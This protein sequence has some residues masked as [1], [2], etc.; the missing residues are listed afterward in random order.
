MAPET[1][2][3]TALVAPAC[4]QHGLVDDGI[5]YGSNGPGSLAWWRS[6]TGTEMFVFSR[7]KHSKYSM[8]MHFHRVSHCTEYITIYAP[9]LPFAVAESRR[10]PLISSALESS[11]CSATHVGLGRIGRKPLG[12][13]TM[14]GWA[15]AWPSRAS[16]QAPT[17]TNHP[18]LNTTTTTTRIASHITGS[19]GYCHL[20]A[21]NCIHARY[22]TATL[23]SRNHLSSSTLPPPWTP[24]PVPSASAAT[25]PN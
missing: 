23:A 17:I 13:V 8:H 12:S 3:Q 2:G 19:I 9:I 18:A 15:W 14:D 4:L 21:S 20:T 1:N 7:C 24:T 22:S 10:R 25:R 6:G 11:A 5:V 16:P